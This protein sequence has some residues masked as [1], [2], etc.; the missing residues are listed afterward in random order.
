MASDASC[1]IGNLAVLDGVSEILLTMIPNSDTKSLIWWCRESVQ[2]PVQGLIPEVDTTGRYPKT[3][4]MGTAAV[5]ILRD[6]ARHYLDNL[7]MKGLWVYP[8]TD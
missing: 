2:A 4:G 8:S 1:R 3:R 5:I 7:E 6:L